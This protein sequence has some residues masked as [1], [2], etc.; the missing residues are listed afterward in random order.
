MSSYIDTINPNPKYGKMA[1]GHLW[2]QQ[3]ISGK[4]DTENIEENLSIETAWAVQ[5]C[6]LLRQ[7][8]VAN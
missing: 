6:P 1:K 5:G 7:Q 3:R 8:T 2:L 4:K